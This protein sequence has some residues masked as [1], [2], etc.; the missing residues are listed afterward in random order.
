MERKPKPRKK[1]KKKVSQAGDG[2]GVLHEIAGIL[3]ITFGILSG[4]SLFV[5]PEVQTLFGLKMIYL[6][7]FG[8]TAVI[9]PLLISLFG[10][11]IIWRRAILPRIMLHLFIIGFI[12]GA[13]LNWALP[14]AAESAGINS[15]SFIS[16]GGVISGYFISFLV[17]AVTKFGVFV[18]LFA[19]FLIYLKLAL[20]ISYTQIGKKLEPYLAAAGRKSWVLLSAAGLKSKSAVVALAN[21]RHEKAR[22]IAEER[23]KV[24][25]ERARKL[26]EEE[27]ARTAN[28]G[29]F[30]YDDHEDLTDKSKGLEHVVTTS[31]E[32]GTTAAPKNDAVE[33]TKRTRKKP[34]SVASEIVEEPEIIQK[35]LFLTTKDGEGEKTVL[36]TLPGPDDWLEKDARTSE[37]EMDNTMRDKLEA[38]LKSFQVPAKIVAVVKGAAFTRFELELELGT[39]VSR[40]VT[41]EQDIALSLA[42]D[43]K[44]IR[45]EAPIPGKSAVG[46]E[47]PN[48]ERAMVP[49][50]NIFMD[51]EFQRT[52][53]PLSF[54]LG[55]DIIGKPVFTNLTK[56]PH[57][58]VA[59]STNSG[60]SVCLNGIIC[61]IIAREFPTTTRFIMVDMKRV[62]LTPYDGIPHLL[63]PVIKEANEAASALR[64]VC[65]EMDKRYKKFAEVGVREI[66]GYN[67]FVEDPEEKLYRIVVLIDELAD[68]MM[69]SSPA[70]NV[71]NYICRITQ[72][73]RATGI[74]MILATQR[75]DTKVITGTIKNNIPS[76]ISFA[77]ASQIDSRTVLDRK[78]AESL[79][80]RGDMLFMPVDSTRLMRLQGAFV[81]DGEVKR[82]VAFWKNQG[83]V[84]YGLK[85]SV[86]AGGGSLGHDGF[87][88]EDEAL[89]KQ[90]VEI[91]VTTGQA[92][93]SMLQRRLRIGYNR[94]ARLVD[95]MEERH[96]VGPYDGSKPREVLLTP[97]GL[98]EI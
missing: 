33:R 21:K 95:L 30:L 74:H 49:I 69:V 2:D 5:S 73:A 24:A 31:P 53:K 34:D 48:K 84:E 18:L 38:T 47:V 67:N 72:L 10:A 3:V 93:I 20:K 64:W 89:Y 66:D 13:F 43:S 91:V 90:A 52:K 19:S 56:M 22:L 29:S 77:V 92:S 45:I 96:V 32:N 63:T 41:L 36:W 35:E 12:V 79:L 6:K 82:L 7:T 14:T 97:A 1:E 71:E 55:E 16:G 58:L 68:L 65:E 4:V 85:F 88:T 9:V 28:P 27:A 37:S 62:E 78:G 23:E 94:A 42:T 8:C 15:E 50:R 59:G 75:P 44:T 11:W 60:K 70:M 57:L 80:G 39:K 25:E 87:E 51:G 40:I 61:S 98:D 17:S 83:V 86:P 54:I 26:M 46:I 76:R 81:S